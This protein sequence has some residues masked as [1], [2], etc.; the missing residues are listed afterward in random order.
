MLSQSQVAVRLIPLRDISAGYRSLV[1]AGWGAVTRLD[2]VRFEPGRPEPMGF[3]V[4][5]DRDGAAAIVISQ[6]RPPVELRLEDYVRGQCAHEGWRVRSEHWFPALGGEMRLE[7]GAERGRGVLGAR[8]R[9]IAF[10]DNGRVLLHSATAPRSAWA[11]LD[12]LLWS[13]AE[14]FELLCPT[15]VARLEAWEVQS[16]GGLHVE[17][18]RSWTAK[19]VS[20]T[21]E[22]SAIDANLN[23]GPRLH[24]YVRVKGRRTF[25]PRPVE[26]LLDVVDQ[27]LR[28]VGI[29][30]ARRKPA[31][32]QVAGAEVPAGWLGTFA[33]EVRMFDG[34]ADAHYGFKFVDGLEVSVVGLSPTV[35][36]DRAGWLRTRRAFEIALHTA[37]PR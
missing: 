12:P 29:V 11:G 23:V 7:V 24:G 3:F 6:A 31:E 16:V 37:S 34:P 20:A 4:Q 22:L 10:V 35:E 21:P 36:D 8:R 27:E 1:P 15:R 30:P 32:A 33:S 9:V 5:S 25:R 2:G 14:S 13:S 28:E 18:P 19:F 26:G 17:L